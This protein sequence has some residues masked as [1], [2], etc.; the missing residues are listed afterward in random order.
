MPHNSS[1]AWQLAG[2]NETQQL[3]SSLQRANYR[4]QALVRRIEHLL[5][6]RTAPAA[7]SPLQAPS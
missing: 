6:Y 4:E 5:C 7:A 1:R 3:G 2:A